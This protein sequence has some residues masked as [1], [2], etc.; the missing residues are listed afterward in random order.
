[1]YMPGA[2]VTT[3]IPRLARSLDNGN[4]ILIIAPLLAAYATWPRCPSKAAILAVFTITP[5]SPSEFGMLD[6]IRCA[7]NRTKL[8]VP[9]T[10][11][12]ED[13]FML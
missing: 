7:A 12:Y 5:L 6:A 13:I 3:R 4:V 10:L 11:T 1:M 2:I 9:V 8:K